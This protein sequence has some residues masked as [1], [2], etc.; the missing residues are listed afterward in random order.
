MHTKMK[1][2]QKTTTTPF[3]REAKE[4]GFPIRVPEMLKSLD[5]VVYLARE[6]V[7]SPKNIIRLKKYI[8]KAFDIQIKGKGFSLVEV[9]SPCPVNLRLE[10]IQAFKWVKENMVPYYPLGE[11]KDYIV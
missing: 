8:K 6:T 3:G 4:A 5:G 7:I 1:V 11:I 10:P 2:K 9:L